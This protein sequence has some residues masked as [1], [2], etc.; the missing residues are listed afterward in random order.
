MRRSGESQPIP[1][2]GGRDS[3]RNAIREVGHDVLSLGACA[4]S[5]SAHES[6][7]S[8]LLACDFSVDDVSRGSVSIEYAKFSVSG[9]SS[10]LSCVMDPPF[11]IHTDG[12]GSTIARKW[13]AVNIHM[14]GQ[15][16]LLPNPSNRLCVKIPF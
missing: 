7:A 4:P 14:D 2:G 6:S 15:Q 16:M 12:Y 11:T 5:F 3:C 9:P 13:M 8:V 10:I 1:D